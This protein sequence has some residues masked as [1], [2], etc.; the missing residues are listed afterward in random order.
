VIEPY[1]NLDRTGCGEEHRV[2]QSRTEVLEA[3]AERVD[4][5]ITTRAES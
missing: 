1:G 5:I 2:P 4:T 3:L